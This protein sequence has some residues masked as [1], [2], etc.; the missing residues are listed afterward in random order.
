[1]LLDLLI[2]VCALIVGAAFVLLAVA[3]SDV[4]K[5]VRLQI[6][7]VGQPRRDVRVT[8]RNSQSETPGAAACFDPPH[9][10]NDQTSGDQAM[11]YVTLWMLGVPIT[12]I[13]L[14][15]LFGFI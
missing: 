15:K 14:M 3:I 10:K 9:R 11:R 4:A 5:S 12:G 7:V 13:V 2:P 6:S 8:L 1:M